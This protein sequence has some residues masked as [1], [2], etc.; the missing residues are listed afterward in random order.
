MNWGFPSQG[1]SGRVVVWRSIGRVGYVGYEGT[2]G[3]GV[4][5][6]WVRGSAGVCVNELEAVL[7][8]G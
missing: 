5:G 2:E 3:A 6:D 8:F 4:W 7:V 1:G